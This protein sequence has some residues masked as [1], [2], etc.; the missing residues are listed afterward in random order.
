MSDTR[1]TPYEIN[2]I[3]QQKVDKILEISEEENKAIDKYSGN[4][5]MINELLGNFISDNAVATEYEYY[6]FGKLSNRENLE[7]LMQNILDIYS[8][9]VKENVNSQQ[10]RMRLYRGAARRLEDDK[11]QSFISTSY[12]RNSAL[13][14]AT[15]NNLHARNHCFIEL[16]VAEDVL[17]LFMQTKGTEYEVL[18]SPFVEIEKVAGTVGE[19]YGTPIEIQRVKVNKKE[20]REMSSEEM[21]QLQEQ[22][23]SGADRISALITECLNLK[24]EI[25]IAESEKDRLDYQYQ[26]EYKN[27]VEKK[28]TREDWKYLVKEKVEKEKV[29]YQQL[30]DLQ[31]EYNEKHGEVSAWKQQFRTLIEGRCKAIEKNLKM[32]L[33]NAYQQAVSEFERR[34]EEEKRREL[35]RIQGEVRNADE[36]RNLIASVKTKIIGQNDFQPEKTD[37]SPSVIKSALERRKTLESCGISYDSPVGRCIT[38]IKSFNFTRERA[39]SM[40]KEGIAQI[41]YFPQYLAKEQENLINAENNEFKKAIESKVVEIRLAQEERI[42]SEQLRNIDTRKVGIIGNL[43]GKQKEKEADRK[44]VEGQLNRLRTFKNSFRRNGFTSEDRAKYSVHEI[45]A[46]I[47][48]AREK[49]ALTIQ[50]MNEL[51]KLE[52]VLN[53]TFRVDRNQVIKKINTKT[54]GDIQSYGVD[55]FISGKKNKIRDSQLEHRKISNAEN[56][57]NSVYKMIDCAE[58]NEMRKEIS[59][60]SLYKPTDPDLYS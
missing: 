47:T 18:L 4:S 49:G 55:S 46:E 45:L 32:Q 51:K 56:L 33:D 3:Y 58:R 9:M 6:S 60:H 17:S 40:T 30:S 34:K 37:Q 28:M 2:D 26:S 35:E 39:S 12:D 13:L 36:V 48:I 41:E 7:V 43:I 21:Q 50:E 23:L 54:K 16:D 31:A 14:F 22:L 52:V 8:A 29:L 10:V 57:C 44:I 38:V 5:V 15:G 24:R 27:F 59:S 20:L 42:L 25:R 11:N 19:Y 1:N 53:R